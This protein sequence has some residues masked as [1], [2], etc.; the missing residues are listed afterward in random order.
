VTKRD[1]VKHLTSIARRLAGRFLGAVRGPRIVTI[2]AFHSEGCRFEVR[3]AVES[4]R[5]QRF[6]G[7]EEFLRSILDEVRPGDT[8]YDVGACIGMVT[9]HAAKR[10]A[11]VVA[12][13]P[14]PGYGQRLATNLALN[15]TSAQVIRWA[16][17]ESAGEAS[18]FTDGAGS[19]SPS[20]RQKGGRGH[21]TVETRSIDAALKAGELQP[22]DVIKMDIEGA[23]MLALRGMSNLL[24]SPHSPRAIFLEL[25][26]D[27]LPDFGSSS[28]EVR[29]VLKAAGYVLDHETAR[30]G[31]VHLVF[32]KAV[33]PD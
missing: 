26:P 9:I 32:R 10:G 16:V 29:A 2:R 5:V 14:D 17:S 25:H 12:F 6:G 3:D 20:L 11:T 30:G 4:F 1:R 15:G 28:D 23:E 7:E 18:L 31:Q 13:E 33:A 19:A 22:P 24:R 27:I 8:V 21:V